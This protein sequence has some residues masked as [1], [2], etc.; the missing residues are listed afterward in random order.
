MSKPARAK[1]ET[2]A[3]KEMQKNLDLLLQ[4]MEKLEKAL[5]G[6]LETMESQIHEKEIE[7]SM[8]QYA[9]RAGKTLEAESIRNLIKD[10][11]QLKKS[12]E[13]K[14]DSYVRMKRTLNAVLSLSCG[15]EPF[16]RSRSLLRQRGKTAERKSRGS[17]RL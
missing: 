15:Q 9:S 5:P 8:E 12:D 4:D 10:Y 14:L 11:T 6:I 7:K 3:A 1:G 13:G 2:P 17:S 16:K